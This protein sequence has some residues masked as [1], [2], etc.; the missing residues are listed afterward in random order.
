MSPIIIGLALFASPG[1]AFVA[2]PVRWQQ[3]SRVVAVGATSKQWRVADIDDWDEDVS[4]IASRYLEGKYENCNVDGDNCRAVCDKNDITALLRE[5]LPPVSAAE[6]EEEVAEVMRSFQGKELVDMGDFVA[7]LKQNKYWAAAGELVVKEL[8]YLDC[9][10]ASYGPSP[11]AL[12]NDDD[13]DELKSSLTW[14]GSAL[15]NLSGKEA[16]FLFAVAAARKGAP[17]MPDAEYAALKQ[18]LQAENSWVV[19]RGMDP[20]EK[21]GM[22]TLL[23][24]IHR[25]FN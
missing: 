14:D 5:V 9:V 4:A 17:T 24:Y 13:Y 10:Q 25:S 3:A 8:M 23:G 21:L 15:V 18:E 1:L 2:Q 7:S 11:K 16:R 6:L 22:Q 20:L 12:L 19:S